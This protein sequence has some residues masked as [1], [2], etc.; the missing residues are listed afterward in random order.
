MGIYVITQNTI[1]LIW[2]NDT[3]SIRTWDKNVGNEILEAYITNI[4]ILI[5]LIS[6]TCFIGTFLF[7]NYS[8]TGKN[9]RAISSNEKLSKILGIDSNNIIVSSV[10]LGSILASVGGNLVAFNSDFSPTMGF[11]LLLYGIVTMIIGGIDS[12]W[13]LLAG[14]IFLATAQQIGA[15]YID[16]KWMDAIAYI[17]L[18]L[19]LIWKPLGFSGKRLKK[20]EI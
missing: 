11:E 1:S 10:I 9:I 3:K 16:S 19:F 12:I 7:L 4:Q 15:Y 13:G 14:A 8:K 20:T 18:I 17:I 2:G 6:L 5:V